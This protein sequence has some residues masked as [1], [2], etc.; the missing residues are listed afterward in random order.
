MNT[1]SAIPI[2]KPWIDLILNDFKLW[3]IRSKF[4]KKL[5]PVAL[6]R[7]GSGTVV[8]IATLSEVIQLTQKIAYENQNY[9]GFQGISMTQAKDFEGEYAWVLKDVVRLKT[10][11]PYKH[12]PGAVT[13]VTLDE[14]TTKRVLLEAENSREEI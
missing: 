10:P 4:T 12:P 8:A 11:V 9:M 13:W 7:S 2:R 5:G 3:E 1:L 14:P 6:I